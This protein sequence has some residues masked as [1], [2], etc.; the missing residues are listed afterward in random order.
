LL[1]IMTLGCGP[2]LVHVPVPSPAQASSNAWLDVQARSATTEPI[3]VTGS[4]TAF[5]DVGT[6]LQGAVRDSTRTWAEKHAGG[7]KRVLTVELTHAEAEYAKGRLG[8]A[9]VARATLHEQEGNVYVA[10]TQVVCRESEWNTPEH[11]ATI[12]TSCALHLG[13]EIEGWLEGLTGMPQ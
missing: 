3:P 2:T 13:R 10:Q 4:C 8:L 11:G 1:V 5:V 9:M 12:V 7:K 6:A